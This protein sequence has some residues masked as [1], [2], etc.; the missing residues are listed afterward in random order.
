MNRKSEQFQGPVRSVHCG[1]KQCFTGRLLEAFWSNS[2]YSDSDIASDSD[3]AGA[4][5]SAVQCSGQELKTEADLFWI[6]YNLVFFV[7][8]P[9]ML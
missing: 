4:S 8:N 7:H 2:L 6:K 9:H 3:S 1:E 5:S